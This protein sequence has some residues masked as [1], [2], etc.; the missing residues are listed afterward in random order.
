MLGTLAMPVIV[1]DH[2]RVI[3]RRLP[4]R[5]QG[6]RI[7]RRYSG[8][9]EVSS[10]PEGQQAAT[11]GDNQMMLFALLAPIALLGVLL[12]MDRL[13]RWTIDTTDAPEPARASSPT[14]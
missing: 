1:P 6:R 10:R 9:R 13:E 2:A 4:R 5:D 12:G 11:E 14:D 7:E 8:A 3:A